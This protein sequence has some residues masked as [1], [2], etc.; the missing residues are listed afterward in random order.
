MLITDLKYDK[1]RLVFLEVF[2]LLTTALIL[3]I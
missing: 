3:N 1:F 2:I